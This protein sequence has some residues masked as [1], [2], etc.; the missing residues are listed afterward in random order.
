MKKIVNILFIFVLGFIFVQKVNAL[1]MS[2]NDVTSVLE[3]YFKEDYEA[4][5]TKNNEGFK[6]VIDAYEFDE[7]MSVKNYI[8]ELKHQNSVIS[9][10]NMDKSKLSEDEKYVSAFL[11]TY[12]LFT[13]FEVINEKYEVDITE[14]DDSN[15]SKYGI[16]LD[17][18]VLDNEEPILDVS[19]FSINLNTFESAVATSGP[20][21]APAVGD[22]PV[23][24]DTDDP[25][26]SDENVE[27]PPTG[28]STIYIII[29]FLVLC[30]GLI[31]YKFKS[32]DNYN[33]L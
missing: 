29:S 30:V 31:I 6:A 2:W 13:L 12:A 3:V 32:L 21:D 18:N 28:D 8:F 17:Y 5:V 33:S 7:D 19:K 27:P 15:Y 9:L 25:I 20:T 11:D 22:D 14:M 23:V 26:S 4:K 16:T 10:V 24:G 1:T